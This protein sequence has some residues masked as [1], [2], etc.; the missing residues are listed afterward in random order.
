MLGQEALIPIALLSDCAVPLSD[1]PIPLDVLPHTADG[2]PTPGAASGSA[3]R[4]ERA[5]TKAPKN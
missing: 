3:S 2:K 4:R 1:G 5:S